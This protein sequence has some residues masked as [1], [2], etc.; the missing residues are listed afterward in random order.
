MKF[1]LFIC[2]VMVFSFQSMR[3]QDTVAL[4]SNAPVVPAYTTI[5][6]PPAMAEDN[7]FR[8]PY[9]TSFRKDGP[10]IIA[11]LG[12]TYLGYNMII[13]KKGI[14]PLEAL[15]RKKAN[16]PFFDRGNAGYYSESAN[17]ASYI[18]FFV[19]FTSPILMAVFDKHQRAHFG[20]V[21]ALFLE[22]M[23]ISGAA[24]TLTAGSISRSRPLVYEGT[25]ASM[26]TRTSNNSQRS[27]FAG[28]VSATATATF[29]A[30]QVYSDFH[31]NSK[32][33]PFVWATAAAIPAIVGYYRYQAGQHFLSDILIGYGVGA[34]VGIL[35][36]KLH[37]TEFFRNL[38]VAPQV[39]DGYKGLAF[40][41]KL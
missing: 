30:A 21:S 19:S 14:T 35:V 41:Y 9:K 5:D 40:V 3:A 7:G 25:T 31:P 36:P 34:T 38:S 22:A 39:G 29:F 27:F 13:N 32:A 1:R 37:R 18:P 23:A 8:S 10:I 24:Y 2:L 17:D 6:H 28:H 15:S 4:A 20:Q 33:K 11:G 26:D 16:L 12:L